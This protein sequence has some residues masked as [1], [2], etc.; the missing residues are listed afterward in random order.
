MP[1]ALNHGA[2]M[3]RNEIGAT[4]N[5]VTCCRPW[6]RAVG[7]G[8][9]QVGDETSSKPITVLSAAASLMALVSGPESIG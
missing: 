5:H 3:P 8:S 1:F 7:R 2:I 4:A 9:N 6:R